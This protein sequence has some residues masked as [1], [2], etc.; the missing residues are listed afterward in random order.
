ML[1]FG[2][3]KGKKLGLALGSGG[4]K[5]MAHLGALK[6]FAEEGIE[7]DVIT[8]TSIG[9][10]IGAGVAYGYDWNKMYELV[11]QVDLSAVKK[12]GILS[13]IM[14]TDGENIVK[15]VAGIFGEDLQFSDL[16]KP[17]AAVSVNL[18]TGDEVVLNSGS[19]C[20]AVAASSCMA[21]VFSPLI[22]NDMHLVDGAYLNPIPSDVARSMGADLVIGIDLGFKNK[23][24]TESVKMLDVLLTTV[25]IAMK[26]ASHKG[27]LNADV[28]LQPDLSAYPASKFEKM[29]EVFEIGYKS[30]KEKMP[31][32]LELLRMNKI[33]KRKI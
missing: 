28:M 10:I 3:N 1:F 5:G 31:V 17:F 29:D 33:Y 27:Y 30:A 25:K 14:A 21:P 11:G 19:V 7:F 32:I 4:A 12:K 13:N 26:S 6:A 15:A 20:K 23:R 16:K 2:R 22:Y 9:S 8:G 24:S 18:R